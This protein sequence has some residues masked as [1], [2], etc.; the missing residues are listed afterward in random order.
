MSEMFFTNSDIVRLMTSQKLIL[1][2]SF[3]QKRKALEYLSYIYNI[4]LAI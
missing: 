1:P 4:Y 3:T 2:V